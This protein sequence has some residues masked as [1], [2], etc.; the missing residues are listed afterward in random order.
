M[1]ERLWATKSPDGEPV[2][3]GR[4]EEEAWQRLLG[5]AYPILGKIYVEQQGW[6]CVPVRIEEEKP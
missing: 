1:A 2:T 4:N 5:S 3:V 6:T